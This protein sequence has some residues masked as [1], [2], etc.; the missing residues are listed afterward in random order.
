MPAAAGAAGQAELPHD[1]A[2]SA[3]SD[4]QL[5]QMQNEQVQQQDA[6]LERLHGTVMRQKDISVAIGGALEEDRQLLQDLDDRVEGATAAVRSQT[7]RLQDI[8]KRKKD[9]RMQCVIFVLSFVFFVVL[10]LALAI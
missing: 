5:L 3:M 10:L 7:K 8:L 9:S 6:V 4:Q 2:F 1:P